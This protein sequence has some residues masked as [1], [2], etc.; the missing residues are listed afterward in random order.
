ETFSLTATLVDSTGTPIVA[1][2]RITI[3]NTLSSEILRVDVNTV[4]QVTTPYSISGIG[5]GVIEVQDTFGGGAI[6]TKVIQVTTGPPKNVTVEFFRTER[7]SPGKTLS[8]IKAT[9]TD[10]GGNP[11]ANATVTWTLTYTQNGSPIGQQTV[12]SA[13]DSTGVAQVPPVVVPEN[14][15]Q[16]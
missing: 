9:V 7:L 15:T 16:V 3:R 1:D 6:G 12:T 11:V 4:S 5:F 14:S 2:T 10:S 13:T 8:E